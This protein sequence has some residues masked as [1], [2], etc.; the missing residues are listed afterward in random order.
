[1]KYF[2]AV[3]YWNHSKLLWKS[4]ALGLQLSWYGV[5]FAAGMFISCWL[6]MQLALR[7]CNYKKY[8]TKAAFEAILEKF[9]LYSLPFI[10]IGARIAYVLFYGGNFYLHNPGEI[11]KIWHG[12]LASH[13]AIVGLLLWIFLF[14]KRCQKKAPFLS[15]LFFSDLCCSVCGFGA[16]CIRVGNLINQEIVGKPTSLPWGIIFSDPIQGTFG[17]PVHPV[18]MYEGVSYLILSIIL[19]FLTFTR[20]L[21]LGK[22]S[23]TSIALISIAL[24]RFVAEF[25][26]SFQGRLLNEES[27]FSMG[28]LLSIPLLILGIILGIRARHQK[29]NKV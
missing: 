23:V 21:T 6:G 12:G 16:F 13:G 8:M 14:A 5:L 18:Q 27:L 1:M 28:Q 17:V 19:Y 22:G 20:K 4:K 10:I 7:S 3:I 11:L 9:A 24:I 2:I 15:F 26:K 25:F 29:H